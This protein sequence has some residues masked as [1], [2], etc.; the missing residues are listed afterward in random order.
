MRMETPNRRP[1]LQAAILVGAVYFVFGVGFAALAGRSASS[2]MRETWN[3]LG[4][5][6]S[7]FAFALHIG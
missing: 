2:A 4:F 3:R 1:W 5:V 6:A 7:A